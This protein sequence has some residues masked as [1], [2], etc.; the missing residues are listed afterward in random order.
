MPIVVTNLI[1]ENAR[2]A[3]KP[4]QLPMA[5]Y[6]IVCSGNYPQGGELLDLSADFK[7]AYAACAGVGFVKNTGNVTTGGLVPGLEP[8]TGQTAQYRLRWFVGAAAGSP[9]QELAAGAYPV[10]AQLDLVVFGVPA[11]DIG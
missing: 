11:T 7:S 6:H 8:V 5:A 10:L 4:G 9:L 2:E 3:K 1:N